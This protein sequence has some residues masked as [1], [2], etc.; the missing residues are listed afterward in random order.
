MPRIRAAVWLA[1]LPLTHLGCR[2]AP[3]IDASARSAAGLAEAD[4]GAILTVDSGFA[5]AANAGN[6]GDVVALYAEDASLLPPNEPALK[7]REAIRQYWGRLLSDYTLRFEL[8]TDEV[9]GRGDLAYLRGHYK[10][11]ASPKAK[12]GAALSDEGK[13][14]EVLKRQADG[15]WR[16][17]TDIYNSDLPPAK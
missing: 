17:T 2:P 5:S 6:L 12:G 8:G 4:R 13:F 3:S 10:L 15:H 11:T 7:G 14:V 1:M 9:D 16:Y